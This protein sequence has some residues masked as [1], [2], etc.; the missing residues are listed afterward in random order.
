MF[1]NSGVEFASYADFLKLVTRSWGGTRD[2]PENVCVGEATVEFAFASWG[3][4]LF[5]K[6]N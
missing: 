6:I 3:H 1:C 5:C 2:K 4:V